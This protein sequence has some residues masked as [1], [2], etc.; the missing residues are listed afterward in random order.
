MIKYFIPIMMMLFLTLSGCAELSSHSDSAKDF[1]SFCSDSSN[2]AKLTMINGTNG[3][4]YTTTDKDR[5]STFIGIMDGLRFKKESTQLTT[6]YSFDVTLYDK[7][8]N[9]LFGA[10][11]G[12]QTMTTEGSIRYKLNKDISFELQIFFNELAISQSA[13]L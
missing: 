1:K 4:R 8:D 7:N 13:S 6:G 11:F 9:K 2:I 12:S 3:N 5:I 10:A